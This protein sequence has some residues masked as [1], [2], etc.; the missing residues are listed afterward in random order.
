M[1]NTIKIIIGV[2]LLSA[3]WLYGV[4]SLGTALKISIKQK[5]YKDS[6]EIKVLEKQL[7]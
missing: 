6:L 5:E 7:R 3:L 1:K 2:I 4:I